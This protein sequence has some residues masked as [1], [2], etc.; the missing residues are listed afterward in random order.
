MSVKQ[1]TLWPTEA[2]FEADLQTALRRTF[3]WLPAGSIRHQTRFSFDFGR[4]RIEIDG[5]EQSRAMG[6]ADV[7]LYSDQQS[8]AV[9]ELKRAAQPL[10]DSD[11]AQGLSYARMLHPS[12]PLVAVTN[13]SDLVLLETHTGN[14]WKPASPSEA[15]FA[16][17]ITQAAKVATADLKQAVSTL[18][19]SNPAVWMQAIR[20]ASKLTVAELSGKW[21]EQLLP[22]TPDFLLPRKATAIA[23][24][25][26]RQNKRLLLIEGPPLSGKSNLLLELMS[27]T[28]SVDDLAVLFLESESGTGILQT[29]ATTLS[30]TLSWPVTRDEARDWLL[31]LSRTA[32]PS[33]IIAVDG[34]GP[35]RDDIRADVEDLTSH[36]FGNRVRVVMTLDDS[37]ADQLVLN[38]TGRKKSAIGRRSERIHLDKLDDDE[39]EL[40]AQLLGQHRMI[41]MDGGQYSPDLRI[42]WVLRD[43]ASRIIPQERYQNTK[44]AAGVPP[45]VGLDLI[46]HTRSRFQ[47]HELRR[48]ARA[49]AQAVLND[50]DDKSRPFSLVLESM[51]TYTVRRQSLLKFLQGSDLDK[52]IQ[53]GFLRPMLH[54]S[55]DAVLVVRVPELIASEAADLLAIELLAKAKED[56]KSTAEWLARKAASIPLGDVVGAQ[57]LIDAA[58]R[59]GSLPLSLIQALIASPPE[60]KAMSPGT[61]AAFYLPGAGTVDMT[62]QDGGSIVLQAHGQ[63]HKI[64]SDPG[65]EQPFAYGSVHSYLILSHLASRPFAID[66]E[67]EIGPRLD[68]A[69]LMEVGACPVVLRAA[70]NPPEIGSGI[71]VHELPD[72]EIVCEKSGIVEPITLSIFWFLGAADQL[73]SEWL[74]DA[75]E[76]SSYPLLSRIHIALSELAGSADK[77]RSN[78]ARQALDSRV[79][80]ALAAFPAFH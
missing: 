64:E 12:P 76:R 52:L 68:P 36:L 31:R 45:I 29:L 33:L 54:E 23:L 22:F 37:L 13:G 2:D 51:A 50:V 4:A 78:F 42:P 61:K 62:F 14:E 66:Q 16:S 49:T 10:L 72:A 25:L 43:I 3:P 65:D 17:L 11:I 53:R 18:M 28:E 27:Q 70:Q 15:E 60:K 46:E 77:Q 73:A 35:G 80:S 19:G 5:K 1:E 79:K 57:A 40:A 44:L 26:L 55:G 59:H 63:R 47:D 34:F 32:G 9:L 71:L 48:M 38:S 8:L 75:L 74:E 20:Q 39:F 30:N 7:L 41:I 67:G 56:A 6:R 24:Y 21:D 58:H 69:I